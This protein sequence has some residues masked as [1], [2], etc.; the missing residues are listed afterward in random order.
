[1]VRLYVTTNQGD[2]R[3]WDNCSDGN[4]QFSNDDNDFSIDY[5]AKRVDYLVINRDNKPIQIN[6]GIGFE[7]PYLIQDGNH[8]LAVCLFRKDKHM[9]VEYSG[10]CEVFKKMFSTAKPIYEKE[11][12]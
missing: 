10:S 11:I 12:L 7:P 9:P 4:V 6:V 3:P 5:H 2:S 1:M 8:R